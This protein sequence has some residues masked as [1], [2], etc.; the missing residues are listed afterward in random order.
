MGLDELLN[1]IDTTTN[2]FSDMYH[3]VFP[4]YLTYRSNEMLL[5]ASEIV[6]NFQHRIVL[7]I[8]A[9]DINSAVCSSLL[10]IKLKSKLKQNKTKSK[11]IKIL[12]K[13]KCSLKGS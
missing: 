2:D 1:D 9:K 8:S 4:S 5:H 7:L 6:E 12:I 13:C 10:L 3:G 11:Q